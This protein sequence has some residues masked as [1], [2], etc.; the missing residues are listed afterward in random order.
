MRRDSSGWREGLWHWK[1]KGMMKRRRDRNDESLRG[2][3]TVTE[4][5]DEGKRRMVEG[6]N[7]EREAEIQ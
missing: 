1:E 3:N 2:G 6:E 7:R 4:G 5:R